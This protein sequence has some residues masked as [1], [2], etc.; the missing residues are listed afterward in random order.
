MRGAVPSWAPAPPEEITAAL[1][2]C[3]DPPPS[4]RREK[5]QKHPLPS[6]QPLDSLWGQAGYGVAFRPSR[7]QPALNAHRGDGAACA[8]PAEGRGLEEA[9]E[10]RTALSPAPG[11]RATSWLSDS[12]SSSFGARAESPRI[13]R[14]VGSGCLK[15]PR[16]EITPVVRGFCWNQ[17]N[18]E[19]QR[20]RIPRGLLRLRGSPGVSAGAAMGVGGCGLAEQASRAGS[21]GSRVI[22]LF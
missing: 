12:A 9:R 3:S 6:H 7:L 21:G 10:E 14:S 2:L 4:A 22:P 13:P 17:L 1:R 11:R 5:R 20:V 16:T 15:G 19:M 18:E 8:G